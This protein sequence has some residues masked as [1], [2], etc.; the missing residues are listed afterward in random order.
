MAER[1]QTNA[2][3]RKRVE[4]KQGMG[5]ALK[6]IIATKNQKKKLELERILSPMGFEVLCEADLDCPLPEVEET[7]E[8]FEDNALLKARSACE[9][10]GLAAIADDSGLCVDALD[11]APGVYSAR[12]GEPGWNDGQRTEHL[13]HNL[14][15]VAAQQRTA[16]FVSAVC[17]VL[18]DGR[19]LTLRGECEGSIAFAP[20]GENGFGY[21][22]V[23]LV[24]EKTFSQM[25]D[26][27]KDGVSH[28]GKALR[29]LRERLPS[30]L[31]AN[32]EAQ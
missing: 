10:T 20:Q 2:V 18:P 17:C 32:A 19:S 27:Q 15:G 14:E 9:A 16:R 23:F 1:L 31:Q 24:G 8:T 22:P 26:V 5:I 29:L 13:L 6:F 12:Y 4:K 28:R 11:G 30:F 21:D 3:R 7:G 25:D